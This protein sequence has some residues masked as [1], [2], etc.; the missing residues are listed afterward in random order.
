VVAAD[1]S[2]PATAFVEWSDVSCVVVASEKAVTVDGATSQF[3]AP[4]REVA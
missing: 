1:A 3:A 2:R 4:P